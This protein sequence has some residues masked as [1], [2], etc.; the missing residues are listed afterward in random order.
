VL[1]PCSVALV[2]LPEREKR[3]LVPHRLNIP[4]FAAEELPIGIR[5]V[6]DAEQESKRSGDS[7]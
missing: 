7:A 3:N 4:A 5:L 6:S 2:M 1:R